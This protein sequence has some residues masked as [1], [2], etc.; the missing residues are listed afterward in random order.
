MPMQVALI[1]YAAVYLQSGHIYDLP[2][3]VGGLPETERDHWL[4]EAITE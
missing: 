1:H 4:V 3:P 2:E